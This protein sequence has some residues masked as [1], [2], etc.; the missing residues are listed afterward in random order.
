MA[1]HLGASDEALLESFDRAQEATTVS[2]EG[3]ESGLEL[4]AFSVALASAS[5]AISVGSA[6]AFRQDFAASG[7]RRGHRST[8]SRR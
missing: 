3:M 8:P 7:E 5:A 6:A 4:R 1:Q 2:D